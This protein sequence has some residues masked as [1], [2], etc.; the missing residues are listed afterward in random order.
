MIKS[1]TVESSSVLPD[2]IPDFMVKVAILN[3]RERVQDPVVGEL[4]VER[5]DLS[6]NSIELQ[7]TRIEIITGG[8][9]I[10]LSLSYVFSFRSNANEMK[11]IIYLI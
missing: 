2:S 5:S 8:R 1:N 10:F 3:T 9:L 4:I 6:I 11:I 7:L